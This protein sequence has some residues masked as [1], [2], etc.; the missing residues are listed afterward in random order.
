[1]GK[2]LI[3]NR[4]GKIGDTALPPHWKRAKIV[5]ETTP[6]LDGTELWAHFQ[7]TRKVEGS[8]SSTVLE[9]GI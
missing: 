2:A 6:R 8:K 7:F 9:E 5:K 3:G 4:T 1:L